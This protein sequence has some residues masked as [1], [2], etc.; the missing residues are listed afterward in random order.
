MKKGDRVRDKFKLARP[1]EP[2]QVGTIESLPNDDGTVVVKW[3]GEPELKPANLNC[4]ELVA[5]AVEEVS[6]E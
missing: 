5:E 2:D 1:G 6:D 4:L 3:D